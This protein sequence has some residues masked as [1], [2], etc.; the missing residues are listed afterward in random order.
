MP[1]SAQRSLVKPLEPSSCAAARDGPN[2][3]MPAASRSS[4]RPATSGASG[5]IT[6][7]PMSFSLQKPM[8]ASMVGDVERH[9]FGDLRDPGIARRA[10]EPIEQGALLELPGERMLAAA[11]SDQQHIH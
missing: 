7:S 8:T 1:Y 2:A 5:P 10:I 6:T 11:A 9:A 3:L 4:A